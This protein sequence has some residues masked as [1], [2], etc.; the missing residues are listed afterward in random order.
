MKKC[1]YCAE[2]IQDEAIVC[3]HC[4]RD[5][6]SGASQV[7][8]VAPK[9]QTGC[10]A[11]GCLTLILLVVVTGIVEQCGMPASPTPTA[12]RAAPATSVVAQILRPVIKVPTGYVGSS[13]YTVASDAK[14]LTAVT[15]QPS[16]PYTDKATAAAC[17]AVLRT[18]FGINTNNL[19]AR[20]LENGFLRVITGDG[21]YDFM[22][23][24]DSRT[25]RLV[26]LG[27]VKRS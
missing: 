20:V 27:V 18:A 1:P 21:I 23:M 25:G 24:I 11:W 26:G 4:G 13:K 3:K 12:S 15:F 9:K 2:D 10:A 22:P 14:G 5:L 8:L 7:Q 6:K 17:L 16:L 19:T